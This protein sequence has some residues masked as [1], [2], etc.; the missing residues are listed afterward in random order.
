VNEFLTLKQ[1]AS[2][3]N[4]PLSYLYRMSSENRLP[5]KV[6]LGKRTVRVNKD[7]LLAELANKTIASGSREEVS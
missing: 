2:L 5:G 1:A 3:L 7:V 6:V 4:L